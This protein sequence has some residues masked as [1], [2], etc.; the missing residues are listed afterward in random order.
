MEIVKLI[1]E[2]LAPA[3][4]AISAY[5]AQ[6]VFRETKPNKGTSLRD[7]V[8]R[9]ERKLD[10]HLDEAAEDRKQLY[11]VVGYLEM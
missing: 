2:F 6:R 4:A 11:K 8:N 5:L 3:L 7:A 10:D 1:L 9:T